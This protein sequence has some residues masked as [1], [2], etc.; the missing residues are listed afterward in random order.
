L[1]RS[2]F[3]KVKFDV[4][5]ACEGTCRFCYRG[6]ITGTLYLD[7]TKIQK[8]TKD[9]LSVGVELFHLAGG[10][11]TLHP[12]FMD[13][14]SDF[15]STGI[16]LKLSTN[17]THL[18]KDQLSDYWRRGLFEL[19]L[20]LNS[21]NPG[22][23][24]AIRGIPGDFSRIFDILREFCVDGPR[25][26]VT[27]VV[28]PNTIR[29]VTELRKILD[30]GPNISVKVQLVHRTLLPVE[31]LHC[32]SSTLFPNADKLQQ[33]YTAIFPD[34]INDYGQH[35]I[36][37][38]PPAPEGSLEKVSGWSNGIFSQR[39]VGNINCAYMLNNPHIKENGDVYPC[40]GR[41]PDRRMGNIHE[42][43]IL[44]LY[45]QHLKEYRSHSHLPYK[46]CNTCVFY[47]YYNSSF[48]PHRST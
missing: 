7:R 14:M 47:E 33:L 39:A 9:A 37:A 23:H 21:L 13:L 5:D 1:S 46:S 10:N 20:S 19:G 18:R 17:A 29:E 11:P 41:S 30:L 6:P 45:E 32:S 4:T 2:F 31:N 34:L 25:I 42:T 22:R 8:V 44:Q 16:P 28:L 26:M 12:M 3:K 38:I 48:F 15:L 43:T 36:Q 40:C 35:R 27:F 24:D